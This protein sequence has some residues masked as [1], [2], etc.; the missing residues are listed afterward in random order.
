MITPAYVQTMARYN[1][2]QNANIYGAAGK[3]SDGQR[4]EDRGAFFRSIHGTLNHLLWA[5]QMWMVRF[6]APPTPAPT[7]KNIPE[8]LEQYD[9][10]TEL[11]NA[12]KTLDALIEDW[13]ARITPEWLATDL[14]WFAASAGKDMVTPIP[15]AVTHF[16]NHQT[17]HRGQTHCLITGLHGVPDR[18]DLPFMPGV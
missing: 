4:K 9:S 12:R 15:V 18:T 13:A 6:N 8:G 11:A 2:W 1:T 14:H 5:D 7:A 10:W 3:L 16:F 17:H